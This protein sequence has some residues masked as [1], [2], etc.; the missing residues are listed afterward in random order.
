[1]EGIN[2]DMMDCLVIEGMVFNRIKW[3]KINLENQ[4]QV[5]GI[6][7]FDDDD[8]NNDDDLCYLRLS[9]INVNK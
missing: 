3:K 6:T 2:W 4:L 8:D 1:M 7:G 9:I 5:D